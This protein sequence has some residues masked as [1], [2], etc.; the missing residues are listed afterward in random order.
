MS[1]VH[2][3][4]RILKT[5]SNLQ[6]LTINCRIKNLDDF[7]RDGADAWFWRAGLLDV[8]EKNGHV[9]HYDQVFGN[10]FEMRG[11]KCCGVLIKHYWKVKG[12]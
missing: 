9:L 11:S 5:K 6:R 12:K 8:K 7:E 1:N 3:F 2:D 10:V 4:D